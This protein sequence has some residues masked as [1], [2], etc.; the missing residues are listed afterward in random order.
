VKVYLA[1]FFYKM[2]PPDSCIHHL[3]P[4]KL[5][6]NILS[7]LRNLSQY[8]IPFAR[9]ARFKKSYVI[10]ALRTFSYGHWWLF[11]WR[12]YLLLVLF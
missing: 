11:W 10:Y 2:I 7:R 9:T 8:C 5:N 3:I 6:Q 4:Q 1:I 12:F